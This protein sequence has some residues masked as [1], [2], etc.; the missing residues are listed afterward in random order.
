MGPALMVGGLYL[1][2]ALAPVYL[3]PFYWLPWVSTPTQHT[4][5]QTQI[6]AHK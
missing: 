3:V 4:F 5:T 6:H 1:F 2:A